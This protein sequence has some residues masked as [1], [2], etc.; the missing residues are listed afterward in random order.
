MGKNREAILHKVPYIAAVREKEI[1]GK[2]V[3][4]RKQDGQTSMAF[5]DCIGQIGVKV[6]IIFKFAFLL[7]KFF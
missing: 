6:L 5:N 3:A 7:T 1:V 2:S 4:V